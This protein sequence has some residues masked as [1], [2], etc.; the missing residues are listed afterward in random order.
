M[1]SLSE[2]RSGRFFSRLAA[3]VLLSC[4]IVVHT[5]GHLLADVPSK[6]AVDNG[7]YV[8]MSLA[9]AL[10]DL[11]SRGLKIIFSS[12]VVRPDLQVDVEPTAS[13]L[14][15]ILGQ[16]LEP[17]GL[18]AR[19]GP[20]DTVVVVPSD[21][22]ATA[23]R[24][25]FSGVVRVRSDDAPLAGA[26]VRELK[27]GAETVTDSEGRFLISHAGTGPATLEARSPDYLPERQEDVGASSIPSFET[28]FY[29]LSVPVIEERLVVSP[30]R[31][32]LMQEAPAAPLSL[33]REEMAS[34]PHLGGDFYR[35]LTL[36]PGATGNDVS[37]QFYVRGGRRDETQI[38]IDGQELYEGFHLKDRDSAL[39]LI[40]PGA[41]GAADLNTGG[42]TA[43]Y[44]DR[45]SGVLDMTTVVPAGPRRFR[46]GLSVLS[47][48]AGGS[49]VFEEDRGGWMAELRRGTTD[50]VGRLLGAED[51][52]F[53]DAFAKIDRQLGSRHRLRINALYSGDEL[54]FAEVIDGESKNFETQ[55]GNS[56]AWLTHR[57][58]LS[59]NLLLENAVSMARIDRDRRGVEDEEGA[60]F[61]IRDDRDSEV[62]ALRQTWD[63]LVADGHSLEIGW[64]IREFDS[65]YDYVGIRNLDDPLAQIRHD[66]ENDLT[67][68]VDEFE[69]RHE[70]VH[71]TDR[72]KPSSP[73]T[74]E[75]GARWD[76][77]SLTDESFLSP[78][79]NL[80]YAVG[81]NG[82]L[83]LAWGRFNQSQRPYE[84]SVED[85]ERMFSRVE[86]SEHR[87]V[88]FERFFEL[89]PPSSGLAL[90]V[91]AYQREVG[92]PRRQFVN[93]YEPLNTFPEVEPDRVLIEPQRSVAEGLEIFL[94][95]GFGRKI[96][97]W[98]NYAYSSTEDLIDGRWT[99]RL[100]DE[101]HALNLDLDYRVSSAW[102]FN[103]AWRYHTGW[104]T[105]PL[106]LGTEIDDEGEIEFTPVLGPL[107]SDRVADYHRLDLRVSRRWQTEWG[108]AT[109]FVDVQNVYDREN[110]AGF[111]I[112]IDD[113]EGTL[114]RNSEA[115]SGILPS[116]GISF[117]F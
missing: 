77:H 73:L 81:E 100:F 23:E 35:A 106:T 93:L 41:I 37:A 96:G 101:T 42:F 114:V 45:M 50:L 86:K 92:N 21:G 103:A 65:E 115:W 17:H 14:R 31:V 72:F 6:S 105:T 49:G 104:P 91:E 79:F 88:G 68:V 102:R 64:Q 25:F 61:L 107:N 66:Y 5:S 113:E 62:F 57:A 12:N 13:D 52:E 22:Q 44:G 95:G 99:P 48:H 33:S 110:I 19:E 109:L 70:A 71:V 108:S 60:E 82:V 55:Y 53:W 76:R 51:P 58:F 98:A 30:S 84:L 29:L 40:S 24:R 4:L 78:R 20:G 34:L 15:D 9:E 18:A 28:V 59:S 47:A 54:S 90:R 63:Y 3:V 2:L 74:V 94:R 97:W 10:L 16:L 111:D 46:L 36:L 67:A 112:E 83:R 38:L 11:R 32:S 8:G 26:I 27:S 39:S 1:G 117:E 75:V 43:E 85:G 116:A 89:E 69:D 56:Y 7:Q 80:A 87:I